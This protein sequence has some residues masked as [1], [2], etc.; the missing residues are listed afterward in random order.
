MRTFALT[1]LSASLAWA[2]NSYTGGYSGAPGR[3]TCA[4]SCHGG[5]NGTLV[6]VGFPSA[7]QPLQVYRIV[8]GHSGGASIVNFN[9]T[10]RI[11]TTSS[12]AGSF[13]TVLNSVLYTGADGGVYANPH[14]IDSAVF[15]W[16]APA[17]G[18][19]TVNFYAAAFQGTTTS[20]NGQ[21]R[22]VTLTITESGTSVSD[23]TSPPGQY[24]LEQNYPNPFNPITSIRYQMARP[25][26]VSLRVY[27]LSGR[28]LATLVNEL[29][30]TGS[31]SIPFRGDQHASGIYFYTLRVGTYSVTKKMLLL[32]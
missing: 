2:H 12:V 8:V 28:E 22:R 15:Q 19:G 18:T 5:T 6:V 16:T 17:A 23:R 11:G 31:Y 30:Q 21:N 1:V 7:Y 9:A 3:Q 10:T 4:S 27:D 29:Q 26:L 25:G 14:G 24:T 20:S 32:R 13:S